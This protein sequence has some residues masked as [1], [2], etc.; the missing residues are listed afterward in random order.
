M[1]R[2]E[3][4]ELKKRGSDGFPIEYYFLDE[5][6]PRYEMPLHWHRELELVLVKSGRLTLHLNTMEYHL[7]QGDIA[8]VNCGVLHRGTPEN[9]IYE[10]IVCDLNILRRSADTPTDLVL[11]IISGQMTVDVLLEAD[12]SAAYSS[13]ASLFGTMRHPSTFFELEVMSRLFAFFFEL[14]KADLVRPHKINRRDANIARVS[15]LIDWLEDNLAEPITLTQLSLKAGLNEKYFC[16]VFKEVT[17]KTFSEFLSRLRIDHACRLLLH[18]KASVT[19]AALHSG[20][21]DMS[22]FSKV[23]KK[24]KKCSPRQWVKKRLKDAR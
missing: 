7:K 17:G 22:Y 5:T 20:F 11:P 15:E 8:V 18:D 9:C 19:E 4:N 16:R 12:N 3:L 14:Y 24:H 10:C 13:A 2:E 6:H 23:F 1:K 21:S